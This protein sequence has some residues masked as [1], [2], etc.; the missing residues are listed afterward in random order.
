MA[1]VAIAPRLGA[2]CDCFAGERLAPR[3]FTGGLRRERGARASVG[4]DRPPAGRLRPRERRDHRTRA[5]A[6]PRRS[7]RRPLWAFCSYSP[8]GYGPVFIEHDWLFLA[9]PWAWRRATPWRMQTSSWPRRSGPSRE[10]GRTPGQGSPGRPLGPRGRHFPDRPADPGDRP[11]PSSGAIEAALGRLAG[12]R[13]PPDPAGSRITI[14]FDAPSPGVGADLVPPRARAACDRGHRHR[15]PI[16]SR[17]RRG[18]GLHRA[19]VPAT[20]DERPFAREGSRPYRPSSSPSFRPGTLSS[21]TSWG[22]CWPPSSCCSSAFR[23]AHR[24]HRPRPR[25]PFKSS[26]ACSA[27]RMCAPGSRHD[28]RPKWRCR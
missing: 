6:A 15:R 2:G 1:D 13:A 19:R 21:G 17:L 18:P 16:R 28:D 9:H 23:C 26:F 7:F 10:G 22:A 11:L 5:D 24:P 4:T 27:T 25:P 20:R 8:R 14:D 12:E 3:R